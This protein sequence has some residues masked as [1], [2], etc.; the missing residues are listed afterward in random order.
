[1][2][3]RL[4]RADGQV[5]APLYLGCSGLCEQ[6]RQHLVAPMT[7][8][9]AGCASKA[10]VLRHLVPLQGAEHSFNVTNVEYTEFDRLGIRDEADCATGI[11]RFPANTNVL[12]IGLQARP[13]AF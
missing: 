12:Y 11:S 6:P 5:G 10:R 2:E 1:M 4:P 7:G 9:A 13:G 8:Q 3:R